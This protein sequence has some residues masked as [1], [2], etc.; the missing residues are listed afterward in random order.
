MVKIRM[1]EFYLTVYFTFVA[2]YISLFFL[3]KRLLFTCFILMTSLSFFT[4]FIYLLEPGILYIIGSKAIYDNII[5][6]LSVVLWLMLVSIIVAG[7]RGEYRDK[8]QFDID[9]EVDSTPENTFQKVIE[10]LPWDFEEDYME[11]MDWP[12]YE[13]DFLKSPLKKERD[14]NSI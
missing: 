5:E 3:S 2:I 7:S 4:L 1:I 6:V 12:G 14:E 9:Y 8:L 10:R 11:Y 13:E